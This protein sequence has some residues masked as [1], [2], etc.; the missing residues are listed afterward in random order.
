MIKQI[1]AIIREEALDD[2]KDALR[3]VGIVGMHISEITGHGREGGVNLSWRGTVYKM[4]MI[5]KLKLTIVLSDRNVELTIDT[6]VKAARTGSQGDGIIF[7]Y[8]VE[9]VVRIRT[10]ERGGQALIY[11][12]DVDQRKGS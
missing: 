6:I 8:P 9:E 1:D 10:G 7:V 11:E 2:V 3:A 5:P 12:D 4:D